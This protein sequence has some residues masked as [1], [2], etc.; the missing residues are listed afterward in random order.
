MA[1]NNVSIVKGYNADPAEM[2][3]M[4][5]AEE[6]LA[7]MDKHF[8]VKSRSGKWRNE[9]MEDVGH[10]AGIKYEMKVCVR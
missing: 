1:R 5:V 4:E 9:S 7:W 2:R 6:R 3:A 10:K 8:I